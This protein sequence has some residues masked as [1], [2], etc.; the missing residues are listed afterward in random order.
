MDVVVYCDW[1]VHPCTLLSS[2][3]ISLPSAQ[4]LEFTFPGGLAAWKLLNLL[5]QVV[6]LHHGPPF[7]LLWFRTGHCPHYAAWSPHLWLWLSSRAPCLPP[8]FCFGPLPCYSIF[9]LYLLVIFLPFP[10]PLLLISVHFF[11]RFSLLFLFILLKKLF[12]VLH[13]ISCLRYFPK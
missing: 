4:G 13:S 9:H 2:A 12:L 6:D 7:P 1:R 10:T 3:K 11:F 8:C 5:V